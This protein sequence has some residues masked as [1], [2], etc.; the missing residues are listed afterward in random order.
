MQLRWLENPELWVQAVE[1]RQ[2]YLDFFYSLWRDMHDLST[3]AGK[4]EFTDALL[5][6]LKG[7]QH[8]VERDHYVKL[9]SKDVGLPVDVLYDY[10]NQRSVV[11][12]QK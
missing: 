2:P 10:L 9:L 7:V 4:S 8:P 3:A 1:N 6:L 5:D 12:G 11:K